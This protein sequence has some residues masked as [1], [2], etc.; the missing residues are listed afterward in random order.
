MIRLE[1]LGTVELEGAGG[2]SLRSVL[3]QPKRTALLTYLATAGPGP[4]H[5]RD[6]LLALFWPELDAARGRNALSQALHFLR[7]AL[8]DE[9]IVT[10]GSEVGLAE[11]AVRCDAIDFE[12]AIREGRWEEALALYRGEFVPGLHVA[13]A[14]GFERWLDA[15]RDRYRDQAVD[16]A[17][18]L[19]EESEARGDVSAAAD[20]ARRAASLVSWDESALRR[21]IACLDRLGD[22]AGALRA[23]EAFA[24]QLW[25]DFEAEPSSQTRE[26]VE[27]IRARAALEGDVAD[28]VAPPVAGRGIATGPA[29]TD[30]VPPGP[31]APPIARRSDPTIES[32]PRP[33]PDTEPESAA[34]SSPGATLA[35][36]SKPATDPAPDLSPES[37]PTAPR[38]AARRTAGRMAV[39]ALVS[40]LLTV[41]WTLIAHGGKRP[42]APEGDD[43]GPRAIAIFP[44]E[45][46]GDDR[47]AFLGRG[48]TDLLS[49]KLSDIGGLR[50]V[51]PRA[52]LAVVSDGE[53]PTP[54]RAAALADRLRA[55]YFTLGSIVAYGDR[56]Q[57]NAT[58]YRRR[59]GEPVVRA[60]AEGPADSLFTLVDRLVADLLAGRIVGP[61]A[62]ITRLA[63]A[64]TSSLPALR[65]YLE[66]ED[67]LR[68]GHYAAAQELFGR[69]IEHDPA[70]ALAHY[71]LA[72]AAVWSGEGSGP[73]ARAVNEAIR[74]AGRLSGHDRQLL[75]AL[76]AFIDRD[77][78]EAERLYR[79][80][81]AAHPDEVEAWYFLGEVLFHYG[82]LMGSPI[83]EAG[84]AFERV[85]AFEPGHVESLIH[86]ARL[87]ARRGDRARLIERL[88]PL[89]A[90]SEGL[91]RA[92]EMR[93]LRAAALRDSV[94]RERIIADATR[95][96]D[97]VIMVTLFGT[98]AHAGDLDLALRLAKLLEGPA[99]PALYRA[100][101]HGMGAQLQLAMGRWGA[102]RRELEQLEV[103]DPVSALI[104]AALYHASPVTPTAPAEIQAILDRLAEPG[105]LSKA[106]SPTGIA[107]QGDGY[108]PFLRL[109]LSGLLEA[110]LGRLEQAL[111]RAETLEALGGDPGDRGLGP[112]LA[113]SIR[114][115]VAWHAGDAAGAY[116]QIRTAPLGPQYLTATTGFAGQ[117]YERFLFGESLAA[118]GR[119]TEAIRWFATFPEPAA[120]DLIYL[121]PTHL[122]RARLF[123]QLG[124]RAAATRH[125]ARFVELWLDCDPELR[126][127]V[128][129]AKARLAVLERGA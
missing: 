127:L 36:P 71:R 99:E 101:G 5:R 3:S 110:K 109:Y 59:G 44:F 43:A 88:T 38:P 63:A 21:L 52:V 98:A 60:A 6:T 62:H 50:S 121:A 39:L 53:P 14:P 56:I 10:R 1:V 114:A 93:A 69:A 112:G 106:K 80:I 82:P 74:Q 16:A 19:A 79:A 120:Y 124:D 22:R 7:R 70:F 68:A 107:Y 58:L 67:A 31:G 13:D 18:R 4:F 33:E 29:A 2:L 113:R 85:L 15:K 92:L 32:V 9:V 118:L 126:P 61:R 115:A 90:D 11:G 94:E 100:L 42:A 23:Y 8:G 54:G 125:Y 73:A 46:Q 35:P 102:A 49:A 12:R 20:W 17:W 55:D 95:F 47:S 76:K 97:E 37:G 51:D 65:A 84:V 104:I 96:G 119:R 30:R 89:L 117:G 40:V 91:D 111:G 83:E 87:D 26:L 75:Y 24:R 86:T 25:Q 129:E 34:E 78:A 116:E 41:S 48:L 108:A 45:V 27:G 66:G 57:L 77:A 81:L 122:R 103:I 123:D 128:D 64:T 105:A 28:T 72:V